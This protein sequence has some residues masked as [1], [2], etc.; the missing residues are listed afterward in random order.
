MDDQKIVRLFWA[1]NEAAIAETDAAYGRR[2]RALA[3]RILGNLE[4]AEESVNDTYLKTWEIIPPQRPTYFYAFLASIC[5]HLSFHRVDWKKAAKR[6]A[7]IVTLSEELELCIPDTRREQEMEA[8]EIA[9]ALS[10]FLNG[11]PQETRRIFLRRY[12]HADTIA[13]I[14]ARYCLTESK[15]KM[16]LSRTRAKLCTYDVFGYLEPSSVSQQNYTT[17]DGVN[18]LLLK[19]SSSGMILVDRENQFLT[20]GIDGDAP[21]EQ[22]AECFDFTVHPNAPDAAAAD[23]REQASQE[24][25]LSRMGDPNIGRRPTYAEY[26]QDLIRGDEMNRSE[27]YTPPVSSYAFYDLDGNG[28]EELLIFSD[29]LITS[30]V[31]MKDG[32]TNEGKVYSMYLCDGNVLVDYDS[33]DSQPNAFGE[34]WYHIFR[35]ANDGDPVFSNPKEQSIVRLKQCKDGTWWRTSSTDHYAEFDTEISEEEAMKILNSY[36]PVELQTR[37]LTQFEEP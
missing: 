30:V 21:L 24:E 9:R 2:L 29:D 5:R 11:L 37:P 7:E 18:V 13:E 32:L 26:V 6:N 27:D 25:M 34:R 22:I 36:K 17:A 15:V 23:A 1:R 28:T 10:A 19:S 4:D 33:Y 3:N 14:A 12:Y 20:L 31:G 16:Q 8:K 35:F